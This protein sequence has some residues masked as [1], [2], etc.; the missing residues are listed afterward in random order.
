MRPLG[1]AG[2]SRSRGGFCWF[3]SMKE[4][5]GKVGRRQERGRLFWRRTL[6]RRFLGWRPFFGRLFRR[7]FG[8]RRPQRRLL[9]RRRRW[10]LAPRRRRQRV[11]H[12]HAAGPPVEFVAPRPP[13][14]ARRRPANLLRASHRRDASD[15]HALWGAGPLRS[16]SE[17]GR[18]SHRR[19][20]A[21]RLGQRLRLRLPHRAHRLLRPSAA[22]RF[23]ERVL[24]RVGHSFGKRGRIA[25]RRA[26]GAARVG[27]APDR[28]LHRRRRRL[29]TRRRRARKRPAFVLPGHGRA[30]L[31]LHPAER[32]ADLHGA[33]G[34]EGRRSLR[35]AVL[36]RGALP[37]GVLRR[38]QRRL[39]RRV[40][41]RN[42]RPKPSWTTRPWA[43]WRTS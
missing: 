33:A 15:E 42:R 19:R 25:D 3:A 14:P 23:A 20:G 17:P 39:Q 7:A 28:L 5:H 30:A 26:R 1:F 8:R 2:F 16:A 35:Q 6:V 36:R 11:R 10:R 40:R 4:R 32:H 21:G 29:D 13:R 22:E 41:R 43:S 34:A 9:V 37:A 12:G 18:P 38:R 27:R 31:R 24:V